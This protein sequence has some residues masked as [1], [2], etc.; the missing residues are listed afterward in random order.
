M[1]SRRGI[2]KKMAGTGVLSVSSGCLG[3]FGGR[4]ETVQF[5]ALLP[6][7]GSLERLGA[8]GKRAA[9]QAV[10]D[11]NDAG[12]INGAE[13][14]LT[15]LDTEASVETATEQYRSLVEQGIVGFVGGLISDVSI[16]LA[17]EAASDAVMEVSPASTAPQL[18]TAGRADGAKY[19]GRVVP[20]DGAQAA[21]MA[22]AL[23]DPMHV[24]ADSVAL[25]SIDNS[26]GAGLAEAQKEA[27]DSE[28]V[29]DVRFDPAA[30]SFDDVL[31]TVF[32]TDPD[33]VGFTCAA[34]Q[35]R[36]VL[37]AYNQSDHDVPWVFSSG[38]FGGDLP[39]YYEGFYSASFS[40]GRTDGYFDLVRRFTDVDE[41]AAY[42]VNAYDA[43]FLMASA[44]RR[45][46]RA[47]ARP[48]PKRFSRS[49][50]GQ[51]TPSPSVISTASGRLSKRVVT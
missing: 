21:V 25:L 41:P 7:S 42:A 22:K 28:G 44:P 8:H 43:L 49:P 5:G 3:S 50:A 36:G 2:L 4:G 14:E 45:L 47:A 6:L 18:S 51:A 31:G 16:A 1:D 40:S 38:M 30:S 34:G 9:E 35:E 39:S 10:A 20:S 32:E 33:A 24:G 12:G 46:A 29:A 13:V 37:D 27:L 11:I 48:S 26:F 19:F 23:N 15:A 17:P